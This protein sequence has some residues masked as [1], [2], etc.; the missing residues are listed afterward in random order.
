MSQNKLK[1]LKQNYVYAP[2]FWILV[3]KYLIVVSGCIFFWRNQANHTNDKEGKLIE[4]LATYSFVFFH[5]L[6]DGSIQYSA[7]LPLTVS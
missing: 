5:V 2:A 1:P 6:V 4:I 7:D 3:L